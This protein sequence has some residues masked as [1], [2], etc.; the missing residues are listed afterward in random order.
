VSRWRKL[1][2]G[3]AIPGCAALTVLASLTLGGTATAASAELSIPA[4]MASLDYGTVLSENDSVVV[5]YRRAFYA[6]KA[7]CTERPIRVADHIQF[8]HT[9][10]RKRGYSV[11][12]LYITRQISR[13]IPRSL[14]RTRCGDIV[15]AWLV[16]A[17]TG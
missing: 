10:L 8:A 15:A 16:V 13:S 3:I 11:T 7:K 1:W 12:R 5:P 14:G 17:A 2:S 9:Y 6:L 4:K